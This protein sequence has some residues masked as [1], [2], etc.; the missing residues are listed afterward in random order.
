MRVLLEHAKTLGINLSKASEEGLSRAVS[1]KQ[2]ANWLQSNQAALESA[3]AYV[4]RN[5]IP[6]A[7]H[8]NL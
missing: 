1:A 7:K 6:L 5:G 3:N 8:R 4:D 2:E